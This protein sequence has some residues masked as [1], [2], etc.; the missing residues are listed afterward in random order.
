MNPQPLL[1]EDSTKTLDYNYYLEG[2][3]PYSKPITIRDHDKT[4]TQATSRPI[5][6]N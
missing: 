5:T 4:K 6:A 2:L 3:L 1:Q